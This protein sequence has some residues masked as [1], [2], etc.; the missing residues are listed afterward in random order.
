VATDAAMSDIDTRRSQD[1]DNG[2]YLIVWDARTNGRIV[3]GS[4]EADPRSG[5]IVRFEADITW[6]KGKGYR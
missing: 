6:R 2:N 5:R 4:C 3:S 1:L